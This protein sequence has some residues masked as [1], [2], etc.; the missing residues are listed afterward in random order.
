M[1]E[2]MRRGIEL[3]RGLEYKD[4]KAETMALYLH[5]DRSKS[6]VAFV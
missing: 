4:S 3:Y 2:K 1:Y 6:L 5:S